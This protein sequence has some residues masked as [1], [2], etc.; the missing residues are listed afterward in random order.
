MD[1][2]F[3]KTIFSVIASIRWLWHLIQNLTLLIEIYK[4]PLI[5]AYK[6]GKWLS[7]LL[8]R[9]NFKSKDAGA[10]TAT[11]ESCRP[12]ITF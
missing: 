3:E 12:L 9:S 11:A 5:I 10:A 7:D 6:R 4:E 8:V 2:L 1:V